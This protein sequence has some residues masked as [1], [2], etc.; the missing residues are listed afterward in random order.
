MRTYSC[1]LLATLLCDHDYGADAAS[2]A[3][4]DKP[5]RKQGKRVRG[6]NDAADGGASSA[7]FGA[8]AYGYCSSEVAVQVVAAISIVVGMQNVIYPCS[9]W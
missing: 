3:D 1:D 9:K 4:D 2:E 8:I 5:R 7:V 6:Y